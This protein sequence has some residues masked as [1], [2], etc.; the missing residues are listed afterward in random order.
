MRD[1]RR[2]TRYA[3]MQ[4]LNL[5]CFLPNNAVLTQ[6][7]LFFRKK[8]T[9]DWNNFLQLLCNI[10]HICIF[11]INISLTSSAIFD[12][13]DHKSWPGFLNCLKCADLALFS[14][15][16]SLYY[17]HALTVLC[18]SHLLAHHDWL[19]MY[20]AYNAIGQTSFQSLPLASLK[21]RRKYFRQFR[22]TSHN[23]SGEK[24]TYGHWFALLDSLQKTH[25]IWPKQVILKSSIIF[26]PTFG[27]GF[28]SEFETDLTMCTKML[29]DSI[30]K[31]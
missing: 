15:W 17:V 6:S 29:Q 7:D 27:S 24:S 16:R 26:L 9:V 23:I 4:C 31:Y 1:I 22:N 3:V 28:A 10:K 18:W 8:T 13:G 12:Y 21:T 20:N 14:Y 25:M 30:D 19:I 11:I 2:F 5:W